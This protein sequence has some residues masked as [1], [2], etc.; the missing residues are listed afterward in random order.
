MRTAASWDLAI[1][2]FSQ[3]TGQLREDVAWAP[4]PPSSTLTLWAIH[5]AL[6]TGTRVVATGRRGHL[7][8]PLQDVTVVH[9]VPAVLAD[10]LELLET[11]RAVA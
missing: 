1:E 4:G 10:V 2:P 6:A 3:V 8:A 5:H 7:S 9:A 11:P